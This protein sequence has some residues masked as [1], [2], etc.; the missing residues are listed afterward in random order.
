MPL[1]KGTSRKAHSENVEELMHSYES[2]GKIGNITPISKSHAQR[3]ANRIAYETAR[4]AK[5]G[6]TNPLNRGSSNSQM[7]K[8]PGGACPTGMPFLRK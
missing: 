4:K 1:H 2:K 6:K 8:N 5:G 7:D 3:I